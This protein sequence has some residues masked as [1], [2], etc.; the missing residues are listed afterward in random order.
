MPFHGL[1]NALKPMPSED[2]IGE[3]VRQ[4]RAQIVEPQDLQNHIER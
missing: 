4:F 2:R 1:R 3:V